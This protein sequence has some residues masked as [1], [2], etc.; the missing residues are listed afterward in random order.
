MPW[1]NKHKLWHHLSTHVKVNGQFY[2]IVGTVT[3]EKGDVVDSIV[4]DKNNR[5]KMPRNNFANQKEVVYYRN[6]TPVNE[7]TPYQNSTGF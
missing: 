5:Y 2:K 4:D 6:N 1:C 7:K 3:N